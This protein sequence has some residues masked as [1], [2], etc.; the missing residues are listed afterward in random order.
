MPLSGPVFAES[1]LGLSMQVCLRM[2]SSEFRLGEDANTCLQCDLRLL[3]NVSERSGGKSCFG[4]GTITMRPSGCRNFMWLP[5]WLTF[6]NPSWASL[7]R[8]SLLCMMTFLRIIRKNCQTELGFCGL[9]Y[10][11]RLDSFG[12]TYSHTVGNTGAGSCWREG[13]LP[14]QE[15]W[16]WTQRK[17]LSES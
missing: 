4:W 16:Q 1:S 8:T 7:L 9:S 6:S 17:L 14:Y 3:R 13:R 2:E 11:D 12:V 10:A 5:F 15:L